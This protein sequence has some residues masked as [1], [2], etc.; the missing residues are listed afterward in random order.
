MIEIMDTTLRDGEQT[1]SVSFSAQ[2]KMSIAHLL[3]VDLGVNRIEVAS[4]RVSNGEFETVKKIANW[5]K[6]AGYIDNIEILG[7]IDKGASLNWI[8]DTGCKTI[9][10]LT[11]GSYKHVTEQLRKTPEQHLDDI[12]AEVE[13]AQKLG[14]TV[15]VYLEDW[16]N[17]I[18]KSEDYVYYMMDGMK[19]LPI[20]RFMLPDTLG[21]LNPHS[22][23]RCCRRMST[24]RPAALRRTLILPQ[25]QS[26]RVYIQVCRV[27]AWEAAASFVF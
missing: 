8:K 20:K 22:V 5:A 23:W 4:A 7:F 12:K 26:F 15:N 14:I 10:L 19:D 11:K 9:N 2:E 25:K 1:S 27:W 16:S 24:P 18:V 21:V 6:S 13:L 3:L 17:G